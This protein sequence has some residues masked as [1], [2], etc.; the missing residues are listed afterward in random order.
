MYFLMSPA[1]QEEVNRIKKATAQPSLSME[2]IRAM[3][4]AVPDS[5]EEQD[6]I[7]SYLTEKCE[8]IDALISEKQQLLLDLDEYKKAFIFECVTGKRKVV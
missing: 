7:V 2:K 4:I 8:R 3:R 5:M 1:G 6:E